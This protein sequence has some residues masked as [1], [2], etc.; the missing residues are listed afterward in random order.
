[1]IRGGCDF[2]NCGTFLVHVFIGN[3]LL[4][5]EIVPNSRI[6]EYA[7]IKKQNKRAIQKET[8]KYPH[9]LYSGSPKK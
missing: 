3:I 9:L 5:P 1:M 4:F 8:T 2:W 7:E 6:F